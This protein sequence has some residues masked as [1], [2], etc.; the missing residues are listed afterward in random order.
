MRI[1]LADFDFVS[2][3][4]A[5]PVIGP[6]FFVTFVFF[7]LFVLLN[8]F[9]AIINQAYGKVKQ[10]MLLA[11]P[12]F[13]LSDYLKLNYSKVVDKLSLRRDRILDIQ[14]VLSSDDIIIQERLDFKDW[15]N[16]LKVGEGENLH[17]PILF[18]T[19]KNIFI[20]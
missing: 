13:M 10:D 7:G 20:I 9:L 6:I 5:Y 4:T 2:L 3:K 15:R 1:I 8:M 18:E 12:D 11:Q 17:P 16:K 19:N 14:S